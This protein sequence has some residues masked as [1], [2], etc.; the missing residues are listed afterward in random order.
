MIQKKVVLLQRISQRKAM[1]VLID[2]KQEDIFIAYSSNRH[3]FTTESQPNLESTVECM[4]LLSV[5][6]MGNGDIC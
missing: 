1:S 5:C 4:S 6:R 3:I 2:V